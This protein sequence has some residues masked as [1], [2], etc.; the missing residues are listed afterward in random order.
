[1]LFSLRSE[2]RLK[3]EKIHMFGIE[4]AINDGYAIVIYPNA[5]G[6]ATI[7][8][9]DAEDWAHVQLVIDDLPDE[10]VLDITRP[11]GPEAIE[12]GV[13]RVGRK[14]RREGEYENWDEKM[15]EFGMPNASDRP[16]Q[17]AKD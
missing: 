9:F 16:S 17:Q 7:A 15:K 1:M 3:N 2:K 6:T 14:M 5:L 11:T 4:K 8:L 12:V 13:A 10:R